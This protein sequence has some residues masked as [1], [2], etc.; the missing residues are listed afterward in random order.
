M[1]AEELQLY[2]IAIEAF[3]QLG[4]FKDSDQLQNY[5]SGRKMQSLAESISVETG[6]AEEL[7]NALNSAVAAAK[8]YETSPLFKD[9][10]ARLAACNELAE[11]IRAENKDR[12]EDRKQKE[13]NQKETTYQKAL[14]LQSQERYEEAIETFKSIRSYKDSD[15]Q[16]F[17]TY[18]MLGKKCQIDKE[19]DMA[20]SAFKQAGNY[21]DA[22]TQITESYYLQAKDYYSAQKYKDAYDVFSSIAGYGDTNDILKND[23]FMIKAAWTT[24]GSIVTFGSYE[25]DNNYNNGQ[26]PI[27]WIV[28]DVKNNI[29]TLVSLY[30]LEYVIYDNQNITL[31]NYNKI[32]VTW[33][34]SSLRKWLNNDFFGKAFNPSEQKQIINDI[35][36]NDKNQHNNAN[37]Q[38]NTKDKVYLLSYK[39]A[40]TYFKTDE[41]RVCLIT[42]YLKAQFKKLGINCDGRCIWWLR[43]P[44]RG[45]SSSVMLVN[46]VGG[47]LSAFANQEMYDTVARPVIRVNNSGIGEE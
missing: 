12:A 18:Y 10:L 44:S 39:E 22:S 1:A 43:S 28:L 19:W 47:T 9:C 25:Q 37:G 46:R 30:G 42:E 16:V 8:Y 6:S 32:T 35:V 15:D 40:F 27:E 5:Y 45:S 7:L 17:A 41:D 14:T 23:P 34:K 31:D 4:T 13:L 36:L 38:K 20:I 24:A 3:Q 26:E 33:E 11:K 29:T 21:S 2:D